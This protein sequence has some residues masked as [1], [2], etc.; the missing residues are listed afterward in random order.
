M[1]TWFTKYYTGLFVGFLDLRASKRVP[2]PQRGGQNQGNRRSETRQ[3]AKQAGV[4]VEPVSALTVDEG[5]DSEVE[6]DSSNSGGWYMGAHEFEDEGTEEEDNVGM[7][8][9]SEE[10]GGESSGTE[11][12][13]G[14]AIEARRRKNGYK[15]LAAKRLKEAIVGLPWDWSTTTKIWDHLTPTEMDVLAQD[16]KEQH[17]RKKCRKRCCYIQP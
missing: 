8:D 4:T 3:E 1:S 16:A 5:M 6:G 11:E 14:L 12:R 9:E 15:R 13:E 7:E 2:D 17:V 10:E